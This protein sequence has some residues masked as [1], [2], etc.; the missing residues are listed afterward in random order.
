LR[1]PTPGHCITPACVWLWYRFIEADC[2]MW[3]GGGELDAETNGVG[4]GAGAAVGGRR[5]GD[6]SK[7][8]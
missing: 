2:V 8:S 6:R 3:G 1:H 4:A 7:A 5:G